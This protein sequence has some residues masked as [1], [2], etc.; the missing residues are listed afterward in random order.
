MW[1]LIRIEIYLQILY[2][3]DTGKILKKCLPNKLI[4]FSFL[5]FKLFQLQLRLFPF[6]N[7]M[8][9]IEL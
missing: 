4:T 2:Q 1:Q 3:L 5:L 6:W 9:L 8:T 7:M